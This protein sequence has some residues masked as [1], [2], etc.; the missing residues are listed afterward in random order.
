MLVKSLD[1]DENVFIFFDGDI[2]CISVTSKKKLTPAGV[3]GVLR[4]SCW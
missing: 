3:I 1:G 2:E 4:N